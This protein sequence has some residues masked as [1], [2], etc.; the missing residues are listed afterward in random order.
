MTLSNLRAARLEWTGSGMRFR[1]AGTDPVTPAVEI[2]GDGETG[3]TPTLLLLLSAAACSASDVVLILTKGRVAL[4][5]VTV[6]VQGTRRAEEPRRYVAIRYRFTIAGDG[7]DRAKAER[8][9]KLSVEK[10]CSVM[11]TLAPDIDV[12]YDIA[13]A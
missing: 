10:Y 2:D 9:V 7:L 12:A 8:A 4:H 13:L 6:D 3:P 11:H 1:G 5:R